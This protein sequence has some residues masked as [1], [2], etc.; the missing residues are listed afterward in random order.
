MTA[1]SRALITG[2]TGQDGW[3][4]SRLLLA[5]G[6]QVFGLVRGDDATPVP[7]EVVAIGG[8]LAR[9]ADIQAAVDYAQ[10]DEVYNL[11]GISSVYHRGRRA[12]GKPWQEK[13]DRAGFQRRD[14]RRRRRRPDRGQPDE[15][16]DSLRCCEGIRSRPR[17]PVPPRGHAD[18]NGDPV[19]P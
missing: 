16:D 17:A 6:Y 2:V 18:L 10:P 11:A 8:D 19:Q 12:V 5:D 14:I 4:L 15:A 13:P 1:P 7:D 3:Y 9:S